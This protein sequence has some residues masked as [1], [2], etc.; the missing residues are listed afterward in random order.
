M[1]RKKC[2]RFFFWPS[3]KVVMKEKSWEKE[4][5]ELGMRL[6]DDIDKWWA[7]ES[8]MGRAGLGRDSPRKRRGER[9]KREKRKKKTKTVIKKKA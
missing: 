3:N 1:G 6:N 4:L 8:G 2:K 7:Y 5:Q 9:Q